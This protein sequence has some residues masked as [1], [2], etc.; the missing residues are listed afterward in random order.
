[1]AV[2]SS[3]VRSSANGYVF[4]FPFAAVSSAKR[5]L[6]GFDGGISPSACRQEIKH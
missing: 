3:T 5:K 1:V 6:S 2:S 4:S